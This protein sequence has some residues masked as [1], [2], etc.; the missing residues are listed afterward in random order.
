M[1]KVEKLLQI[2]EIKKI[3]FIKYIVVAEV[4]IGIFILFFTMIILYYKIVKPIMYL[5][6][7]IENYK[8][9]IKPSRTNR[10][11]EI[12]WLKNNFVE[13]TENLEEEKKNQNR[14]IASISHD[15]KT[16]LTSI[17]GYSEM[18][19]NKNI[20]QEIKNMYMEIK[21]TSL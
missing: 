6:K 7:D 17:M 5:Q 21:S 9:E 19:K 20:S 4:V 3:P 18:I 11:D 2:N 14:I 13:L 1:I 15:I 12:G 8:F 10:F 16:P